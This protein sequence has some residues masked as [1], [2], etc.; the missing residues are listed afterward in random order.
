MSL[1][2]IVQV[3][4]TANTAAPTRP[5]F[6]TPLIAAYHTRWTSDRVREY[7]KPAEMVDDGFT[8]TDPAYLAAVKIFS[9]SPRVRKI[10]VGRRTRAFTQILHLTPTVTSTGT[11]LSVDVNGETASFTMG[12]TQTVAA[13]VAGLLAA[14]NGLPGTADHTAT[15]GTT[16]VVLTAPVGALVDLEDWTS[17]LSVSDATVDP[18]IAADIADIVAEDDDWYG[19]VM[20]SN[21]QAE[22]EA[23]AADMEAR[24]KLF[25]FNTSDSAV[26]DSGSTTDVFAEL[27]GLNYA[28]T[29]GIYSGSKLLS[30]SAAAWMGDRFPYDPGSDTWA[31]KTLAGIPTDNLSSGKVTAILNKRGNVYTTIAGLSVTQY[32]KSFSGEWADVTRFI[33]WLRSE[34][35]IRVFALLVNNQKVPYTDLGIDM[36]KAAVQGA[37]DAGVRAGGLSSNPAPTVTAPAAEDVDSITKATRVLPEVEFGGTLAGA[38]HQLE[39]EGTLAV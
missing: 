11:V 3:N 37:L 19:F 39:I 18:G 9:Q 4:I 6:G 20:D 2:D 24:I 14:I 31:F 1:E 8:V 17:N 21:S 29:I 5:G 15:D 26:F 23:A 38:I 36:V 25:V 10:K 16:H 12:A 34:I 27:A 13:A 30:Y 28:R 35:Q 7:A 22:V 33:D 32:G